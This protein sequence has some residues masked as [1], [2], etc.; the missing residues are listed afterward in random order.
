MQADG[1]VLYVV[2]PEFRFRETLQALLSLEFQGR[3]L[4]SKDLGGLL[5]EM[6]PGSRPDVLLVGTGS[7]RPASIVEL[8]AE[9]RHLFP[10]TPLIVLHTGDN[11]APFVDVVSVAAKPLDASRLIAAIHRLLSV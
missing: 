8:I 10:E 2:E 7:G 11:P 3:I 5:R 1:T 6:S 4:A 9:A